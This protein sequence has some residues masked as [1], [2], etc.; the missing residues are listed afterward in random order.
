VLEGR[1][2]DVNAELA[3]RMEEAAQ[4]SSSSRRA[5]RDQLAALKQIQADADRR[6]RGR[7]RCRCVRDRRRARQLRRQRDAGARR[8]Q[9]RH[10]G[11]LPA[12]A[13]NEPAEALASFLMQYYAGRE[14]AARGVR[15]PGAAGRRGALRGAV[16]ARRGRSVRLKRAQRGMTARWVEMVRENATQALRMRLARRD[17]YDGSRSRSARSSA[18]PA[19]RR[20]W[21]ASTS[22]TRQGEGTVASCVVFGPEGPL[23][24]DYR[25]FNIAT[26]SA[27]RRLRRA[28]PGRC[29]GATRVSATAKRATRICC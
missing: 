27:G 21:S 10:L 13:R 4:R 24:K 17:T 18:S 8:P 15:R 25:R 26:A 2:T 23:K 12:R 16:A 14:A 9:P 11:L 5:L 22:A 28:A 20:A 7:A 19:R 29:S 1:D 6:R 3:A